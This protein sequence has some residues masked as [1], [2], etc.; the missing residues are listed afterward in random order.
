MAVLLALRRKCVGTVEPWPPTEEYLRN[1]F[2]ILGLAWAKLSVQPGIDRK[3]KQSRAFQRFMRHASI[4][5][6]QLKDPCTS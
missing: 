4:P 6:A 5:K 1:K 3:S 2:C